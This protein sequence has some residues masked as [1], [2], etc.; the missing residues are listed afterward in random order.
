MLPIWIARRKWCEDIFHNT[1]GKRGFGP[2]T[3]QGNAVKEIVP[4]TT[5]GKAGKE[6]VTELL[7]S[8]DRCIGPFSRQG[9]KMSPRVVGVA[10]EQCD[11][12]CVLAVMNSSQ[13]NN[14]SPRNKDG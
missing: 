1:R 9:E 14:K 12:G 4:S 5:Q 6:I 8:G 10:S 11:D 3:V 13:I 7:S 2:S